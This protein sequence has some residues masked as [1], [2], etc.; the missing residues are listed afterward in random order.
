MY[1]FVIMDTVIKFITCI[2]GKIWNNS[3][4]INLVGTY[5]PTRNTLWD[6]K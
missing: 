1:A 6:T 3:Q 2:K 4:N 5:I